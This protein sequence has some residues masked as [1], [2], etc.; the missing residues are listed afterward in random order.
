MCAAMIGY[1]LRHGLEYS[2]PN[3][4]NNTEWNVIG[5]DHLINPKW[6]QGREDILINENWNTEQHYQEIPFDENWR[7]QQ[8]VLNGYW[9]SWRYI[10]PYR[11][12]VIKA[13]NYPYEFNEGVCAIHVRR[14]DYLLYPR[15]HP[16][17]TLEYLSKA[18]NYILDIDE[19][20]RFKIFSDDIDWCKQN[21]PSIYGESVEYSENKTPEQDLVLAANCEHIICS[22][23]S[24]AL[25]MA[26]L[27][28]NPNKIVIVPH[29][30]NWFGKDNKH[31]AVK[32]LFRKEWKQ[33]PYTPIYEL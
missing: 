12:E 26:E 4:T 29:E 14:G 17:I 24:L 15:L 1:A 23:S 2:V 8:I 10:Q 16:V 6:V 19:G 32:D 30:D 27:N 9:Q 3:F 21:I 13:F 31:L 25:W 7:E 20:L 28:Q 22:N 18:V 11:D 5:F 33:I